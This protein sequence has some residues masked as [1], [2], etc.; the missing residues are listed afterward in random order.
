VQCNTVSNFRTSTVAVNTS[1]YGQDSSGVAKVHVYPNPFSGE[2]SIDVTG[3]EEKVDIKIRNENGTIV[4][5]K[6]DYISS[7]KIY[8]GDALPQG[9]YLMEVSSGSY[10]KNFKLIKVSQ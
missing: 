4:F 10:S 5:S 8:L 2:I 9:F 1:D 6:E 7:E 3:L